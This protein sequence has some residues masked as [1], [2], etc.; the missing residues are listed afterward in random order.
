MLQPH[1][2]VSAWAITEL[3]DNRGSCRDQGQGKI[4]SE[5]RDD[6]KAFVSHKVIAPREHGM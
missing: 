4:C 6:G 3:I 2:H 1:L 5:H